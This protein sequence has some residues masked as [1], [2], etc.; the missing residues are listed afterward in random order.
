MNQNVLTSKPNKRKLIER[1]RCCKSKNMRPRLVGGL[2]AGL[3]TSYLR[4]FGAASSTKFHL[5]KNRE[6]VPF[7]VNRVKTKIQKQFQSLHA[8]EGFRR[9]RGRQFRSGDCNLGP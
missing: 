5:L 6:G 2:K 7:K 8:S 4:S 3:Q 9:E 1:F